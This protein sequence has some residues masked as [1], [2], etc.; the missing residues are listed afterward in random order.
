MGNFHMGTYS[1]LVFVFRKRITKMYN[2]HYLRKVSGV[3]VL[4]IFERESY[5]K[6][7]LSKIKFKL[8]AN[9]YIRL[10]QNSRDRPKNLNYSEFQII[11]V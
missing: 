10:V 7:E 2:A 4:V 1:T 6:F 5:E 8:P 3:I 11:H 9:I